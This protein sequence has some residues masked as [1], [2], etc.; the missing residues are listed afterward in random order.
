M[1]NNKLI[2]V[3][4]SAVWVAVVSSSVSVSWISISIS[5]I[6]SFW[7]SISFGFTLV[8]LVDSIS[9][10]WSA[11]VLERT[12]SGKSV[13]S[14]SVWGIS[15]SVSGVW[16]IGTIEYSWVSISRSLATVVSISISVVWVSITVSMAIVSTISIASISKTVSGISIVG[17]WR[18]FSFWFSNN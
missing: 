11:Y 13:W 6:V 12:G 4:V 5:A 9:G 15:I 3:S 18:C 14:I 16:G 7:F 10:S 2:M 17:F 1:F 8:Q